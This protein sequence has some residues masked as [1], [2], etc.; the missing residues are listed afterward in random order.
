M[1][2]GPRYAAVRDGHPRRPAVV[3]AGVPAVGQRG[4]EARR[5]RGLLVVNELGGRAGELFAAA[6]G[7]EKAPEKSGLQ[8]EPKICD[9]S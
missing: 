8:D 9:L 1:L 3:Q 2:R 4:A 7:G 6:S 5:G